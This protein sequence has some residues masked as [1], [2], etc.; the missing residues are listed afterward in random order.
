MSVLHEKNA[1]SA[2]IKNSGYIGSLVWELGSYREAKLND[3]PNHVQLNKGDTIITSGYSAVYPEGIL[4]GTIKE[5]NLAE[6]SNFYNI[7]VEFTVDYKKLSHVFI[8]KN[9]QKEEQ[10]QLEKLTEEQE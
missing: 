1:V 8:V 10:K 6:G 7:T 3:I 2:K 5:F 9:K 4:I